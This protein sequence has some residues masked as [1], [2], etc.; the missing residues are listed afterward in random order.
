MD[1]L[2]KARKL[3]KES[4]L[5]YGVAKTYLIQAEFLIDKGYGSG[6]AIDFNPTKITMFLI[7][8]KKLF[9]QYKNECL[10][11]RCLRNLA[12]LMYRTKDCFEAKRNIEEAITVAKRI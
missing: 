2:Q 11:I 12:L 5:D 6:L 1:Y 3:Y 7:D 10:E 9:K 4:D 8:A